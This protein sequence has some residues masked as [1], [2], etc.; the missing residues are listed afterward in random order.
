MINDPK[1]YLSSDR[2]QMR[3]G[4]KEKAQEEGWIKMSEERKKYDSDRAFAEAVSSITM[5]T[6]SEL[7]KMSF[8]QTEMWDKFE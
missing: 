4:T 3:I 1:I 2:G 5:L 6:K 7:E 8:K